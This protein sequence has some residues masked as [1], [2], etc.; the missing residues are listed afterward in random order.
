MKTFFPS[1]SSLILTL[2]LLLLAGC[3][4]ELPGPEEAAV[5]GTEPATDVASK[6]PAVLDLTGDWAWSAVTLVLAKPLIFDLGFFAGIDPEGPITRMLCP[7]S[8]ILTISTQ[9]GASF[10]GSATQVNELCTTQ[11]GQTALPPF[12]PSLNVVD[13]QI[14]GHSFSYTN[15]GNIPDA[16]PIPCHFKGAIRVQ[17]G[18]A[19]E[20]KGTGQCEVPK[21]FGP[22]GKVLHFV[23]TRL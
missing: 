12:P 23:A 11:G 19:V 3:V 14:S 6:A 21:D 9:N 18:V 10:S 13:G 1:P 2:V 15:V 20:L 4:D 16:P 8:G 22:P 7:S 17:G 5:V